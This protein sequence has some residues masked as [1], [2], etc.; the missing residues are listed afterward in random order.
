MVKMFNYQNGK[1]KIMYNEQGMLKDYPYD[2]SKQ[3]IE[4][5]TYPISDSFSLGIELDV[6]VGG[7][8]DYGMLVAQVEPTKE[9]NHVT[10]SV[11]YTKKNIVKYQDS[12]LLND[13][14]VYKGLLEEYLDWVLERTG[15]SILKK[16]KYP[17]CKIAFSDAANCEVGSSPM[18]FGI[19]AEMLI[20]MIY[21][22][23]C[24]K[25][26]TMDIQ[27]FTERYLKNTGLHV[28]I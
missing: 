16:E 4:I 7:K 1:I 17:Q 26:L 11:E 13:K 27:S 28:K 25:I 15:L 6:H 14:Y 23:S 2:C 19:I 5:K 24:D 3:Q 9:E 8:I 10:L 18:L 20:D 21:I 22:G 12:Q